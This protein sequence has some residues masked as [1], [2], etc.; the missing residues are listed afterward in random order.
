M[1]PLEIPMGILVSLIAWSLLQEVGSIL[2][3]VT[4]LRSRLLR[5]HTGRR[6]SLRRL[7][8]EW[9]KVLLRMLRMLWVLSMLWVLWLLW[10]LWLL[11][12][13]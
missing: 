3:V 6:L 13:E 9:R 2:V 1:F 8:S 11:W 7:L 5:R 4:A 10:L 12:V